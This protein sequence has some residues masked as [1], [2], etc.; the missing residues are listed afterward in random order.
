MSGGG[1]RPPS[2]AVGAG[3]RGGGDGGPGG[4]RRDEGAEEFTAELFWTWTK[5]Y[6]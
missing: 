1:V 2:V 5:A 3:G 6:F 4:E